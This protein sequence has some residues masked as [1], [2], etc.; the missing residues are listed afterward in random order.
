LYNWLWRV[1]SRTVLFRASACTHLGSTVRPDLLEGVWL[2][3]PYIDGHYCPEVKLEAVNGHINLPAGHGL[4]ITP[5]EV[6]I[7]DPT[8]EF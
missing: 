1:Y 2:A 5:D 8:V 4:G 7:G 3:A 6:I